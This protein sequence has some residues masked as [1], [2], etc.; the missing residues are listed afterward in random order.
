[1]RLAQLGTAEI[2]LT[3]P[4]TLAVLTGWGY[5]PPPGFDFS[6]LDAEGATSLTAEGWEIPNVL[7]GVE[8]PLVSDDSCSGPA[9]GVVCG[10][11]EQRTDACSADSGGPL[12]ARDAEGYVQIGLVSGGE[13]CPGQ[14][15]SG[16]VGVYTRV[17]DYAHWIEQVMAGAIAPTL[18][19]PDYSLAPSFGEITLASGFASPHVLEWSLGGLIDARSVGEVCEGFIA[20]EPDF[21]LLYEAGSAA[22]LRISVEA[23]SDSSL[24]VN[25]ADGVW[26]CDDGAST[27]GVPQLRWDSPK[28]GRY[29]IY[30]GSPQVGVYPPARLSISE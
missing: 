26:S 25:A 22:S 3:M 19:G 21:R 17:A 13:L 7:H 5:V 2:M 20:R 27:G 10:G 4:G 6:L 28:S 29:D 30:L 8:I 11:F 23:A 9:G 12:H 1:V 14:N 16:R 18:A 24:V 15:Y